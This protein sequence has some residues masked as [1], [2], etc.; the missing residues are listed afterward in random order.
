MCV[1]MWLVNVRTSY[2]GHTFAK[3]SDVVGEQ[4]SDA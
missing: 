2:E 3:R 4:R 1:S